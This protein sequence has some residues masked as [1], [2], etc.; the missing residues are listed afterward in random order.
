[1]QLQRTGTKNYA[2]LPP[3]ILIVDPNPTS[4]AAR[5][6]LL[7]AADGYSA[8]TSEKVT[9]AFLQDASV[10]IAILSE[11]LGQVAAEGWALKIRFSWPNA[12]ILILGEAE[13]I[14][15]DSL[16]D[17]A[18]D[19]RCRPEQLLEALFRLGRNSHGQ[20]EVK[21]G[22]LGSES[23]SVARLRFVSPKG[24]P[25]ESDPSKHATRND[26]DERELPGD[27]HSYT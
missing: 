1:V 6:M 14:L 24:L 19:H 16:F 8:A 11:S 21:G 3:G 25:A 13:T 7:Q 22:R 15:G 23:T 10:K 2:L 17:E 20:P 26:G 5:A 18:I 27:E 4:L 12:R 9:G